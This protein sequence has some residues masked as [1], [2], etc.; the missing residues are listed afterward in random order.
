[1]KYFLFF[2]LLFASCT[3]PFTSS[4]WRL[5][6]DFGHP[7]R[8]E[9]VDDLIAHHLHAG[10]RY[11][12][13]DSLLGP[14]EGRIGTPLTKTSYDVVVNYGSDIDPVDVSYLALQWKDS[15][16]VEYRVVKVK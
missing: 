16:L 3:Q 2:T 13:V 10:M 5:V 1:M 11:Q 4:G 7:N 6:Y 12:E 14:P 15:V 9:M 8:E